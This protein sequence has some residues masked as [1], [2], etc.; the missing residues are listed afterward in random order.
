LRDVIYRFAVYLPASFLS[1]NS[2]EEKMLFLGIFLYF[3]CEKPL[4]F[5]IFIMCFVLSE[6]LSLEEEEEV[7]AVEGEEDVQE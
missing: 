6:I 4:V 1:G 2:V 3:Y 5:D 7:E